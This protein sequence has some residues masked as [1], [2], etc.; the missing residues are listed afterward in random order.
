MG[1][2]QTTLIALAVFAL[3]YQLI[4]PERPKDTAMQALKAQLAQARKLHKPTAH[5]IRA[6]QS[7]QHERLRACR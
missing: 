4:P 1:L 2:A 7:L 6:M 5:I 3:F